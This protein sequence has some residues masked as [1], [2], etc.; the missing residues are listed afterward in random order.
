MGSDKDRKQSPNRRNF[1][2][3]GHSHKTKEVFRGACTEM[4]GHVYNYKPGAY[5]GTDEYETTTTA[6]INHCASTLPQS[7]AVRQSLL[8]LRRKEIPKPT[9]DASIPGVDGSPPTHSKQDEID[10]KEDRKEWKAANNKLDESLCKA[11]SIALGQTTDSMRATIMES[12]EWTTVNSISDCIGLLK[13]IKRIAHNTEDQKNP[14]LSLV[15]A[16]KRIY[17]LTQHDGE[18]PED[19]KKRFD[20][21][22]DVISSMKGTIYQPPMLTTVA[23]RVYGKDV[24]ALTPPE[25]QETIRLADELARATLFIEN[26]NNKK[27]NQL[28]AKLSND[29][30]QG[31]TNNYPTTMTA[32]YQMLTQFK[33]IATD[34]VITPSEG[35]SFGQINKKLEHD[36]GYNKAKWDDHECAL[37]G[38][39]GH[40]PY[41]PYCSVAKAF[42]EN[43]SI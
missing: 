5:S 22:A 20:N 2:S 14:T 41:S 4:N 40:P 15:Q 33:A 32:A 30:V 17:H 18:K 37:C 24:I 29:H 3:H 35:T 26:S 31:M 34:T 27:Y 23:H 43:P 28:K 16:T 39:M 42:E 19:Y 9:Y 10:Y 38:K 8:E 11:F 13:I 36:T 12:D 21:M 1:K 7:N 6:L 25:K